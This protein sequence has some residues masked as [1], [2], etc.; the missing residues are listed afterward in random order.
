MA[1]QKKSTEQ[2]QGFRLLEFNKGQAIFKEGQ[3]GRH[4][5]LIRSGKVAIYKE[6]DGRKVFVAHM[7]PGQILGEMAII[8]GEPRSA[9]AEAAEFCELLLMDEKTLH[10]ALDDTLP[11][12]KALLNQLIV[13]IN[14]TD[15]KH[16]LGKVG[17]TKNQQRVEELERAVR[18]IH[19]EAQ[20]WLL[21]QPNMDA[22]ARKCLDIISTICERAVQS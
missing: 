2:K 19:G 21:A 9:S 17:A 10:S 8:T 4:A 3:G 18:A 22:N 7:V 1:Q 14:E 12:I 13:R 16:P 11:I 5:Y 15:K 6:V 20:D